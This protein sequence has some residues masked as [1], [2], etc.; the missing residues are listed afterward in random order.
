MLHE[1]IKKYYFDNQKRLKKASLEHLV[2]RLYLWNR[3][4]EALRI[5]KK[6]APSA[7]QEEEKYLNMLQN[8]E[9]KIPLKCKNL[10]EIREP[11]FQKYK[12]LRK[13]NKI[14]FRLTTAYTIYGKDYKHCLFKIFSKEEIS[15]YRAALLKDTRALSIL[16]SHAINFLYLYSRLFDQETGLSLKTIDGII[17][18]KYDHTDAGDIQLM[19]YFL[20]HCIIGETQYYFRNI[21]E[22][23]INE[24]RKLLLFIENV[25]EKQY[26]LIHLDNKLEFLVCCKI[27]GYPSRLTTIIMSEAGN[28]LSPKGKFIIDRFNGNPQKKHVTLTKSEHRNVL[29]I[30]ACTSWKPLAGYTAS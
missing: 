5:L 9:V 16:S 14:L 26:F 25:I 23:K 28:S 6:I 2:S 3:D 4:P 1:E 13:F 30:M 18:K 12:L 11:F 15:K 20:T 8:M 10:S 19:I 17:K 24:Y 29:Y 21:P 27:L 22:K 7:I